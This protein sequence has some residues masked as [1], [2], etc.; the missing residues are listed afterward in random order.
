MDDGGDGGGVVGGFFE[1]RGCR[2]ADV[3]LDFS[4]PMPMPSDDLVEAGGGGS[5][6][7]VGVGFHGVVGGDAENGRGQQQAIFQSFSSSMGRRL[8]DRARFFRWF[9]L[10]QQR[11]TAHC[12]G[13]DRNA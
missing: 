12:C 6:I 13:P 7:A 2:R 1:G 9:W 3:A 10:S 5:G 4:S 11:L 8:R